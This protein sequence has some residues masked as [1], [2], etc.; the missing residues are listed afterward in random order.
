MFNLEFEIFRKFQKQLFWQFQKK[1]WKISKKIILEI[2]KKMKVFFLEG[3]FFFWR[4]FSFVSCFL[5]VGDGLAC[6]TR[7]RIRP[8]LAIFTGVEILKMLMIFY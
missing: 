1:N 7:F 2:S 6:K 5:A 3:V 4:F 8:P